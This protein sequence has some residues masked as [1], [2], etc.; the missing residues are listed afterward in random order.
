M[1]LTVVRP[2]VVCNAP[3]Q[4]QRASKQTCSHKCYMQLHRALKR[5][6]PATP[7]QQTQNEGSKNMSQLFQ[8]DP[9]QIQSLKDFAEK[10]YRQDVECVIQGREKQGMYAEF[11]VQSLQATLTLYAELLGQGYKPSPDVL[12]VPQFVRGVTSDWVTLILIKPDA[13]VAEEI[14]AIHAAE[15]SAYMT[16]LEQQKAAAVERE[17]QSLL[18]SERGKRKQAELDAKAAQEAE[19]YSRTRV[20]VLQAL[21]LGEQQ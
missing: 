8:P 11:N 18:D 7:Q 17:V 2:C 4:T 15:E 5:E 10:Q 19:E 21:G 14:A 3:M 9:Q 6:P 20:E 1:A 12:H 13:V 16:A